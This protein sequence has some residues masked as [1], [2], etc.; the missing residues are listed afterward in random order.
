MSETSTTCGTIDEA[1]SAILASSSD[2]ET[3]SSS[4]VTSLM[5]DIEKYH[6]EK[7]I[8][9]TSKDSLLWWKTMKAVYPDLA[10]V[11]CQYLSCP[12]SSVPSEQLFSGAGLIYDAKRSRLLPEKVDKLLFLKRNLPILK[13]EY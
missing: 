4:V 8:S 12:P 1:L 3:E 9:G 11:A 10:K 5:K 6:T 13:F 2:D 7:R